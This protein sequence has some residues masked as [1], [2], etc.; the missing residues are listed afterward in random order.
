MTGAAFDT[1]IIDGLKDE[2]IDK[3]AS[4]LGLDDDEAPEPKA[5]AG[6]TPP[7]GDKKDQPAPVGGR[8][9]DASAQ[10]ASGGQPKVPAGKALL[11]MFREDKEAQSL[12]QQQLDS[13]LKQASA[14][15]DAKKEQEA[16]QKLIADGDY[17]EIGKRYVT[18]EQT[19]HIQSQAAEQAQI[20]AYGEIYR[21][22]FDQ[23][24]IKGWTP[25]EKLKYDAANYNTDA[26]YVLALTDFIA[27]KRS[28]SSID[29]IVEKKVN[30]RL[31]TLKNMKAG[32]V[33][34]GGSPSSLPGGLPRQEGASDGSSRSLISEGFKEA[35]EAAATNRVM[36]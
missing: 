17:E 16:F 33:A 4:E 30:E 5:D 21:G 27:S 18:A 10:D 1:S 25:E 7:T 26:E 35:L 9:E 12:V 20:E 31:E 32:E 2:D 8:P 23:P 34:T 13:W 29:D 6:Q 24:E 3:L 36:E 28:G 19:K 15:A 22:I 14:S 11:D